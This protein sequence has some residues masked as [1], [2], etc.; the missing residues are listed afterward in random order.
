METQNAN[1]GAFRDCLYVLE[2]RQWMMMQVLD[3]IARDGVPIQSPSGTV[4]WKSYE[5]KYNAFLESQKAKEP[6][7]EEPADAVIFGG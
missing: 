7:P 3:D 2:A 4:D 1:A 6:L 5:A